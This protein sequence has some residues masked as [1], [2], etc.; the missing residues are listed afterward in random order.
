MRPVD[1]SEADVERSAL[2]ISAALDVANA[3]FAG[4]L[5]F[6]LHRRA[7]ATGRDELGK[8]FTALSEA[9][10]WLY[11]LGAVFRCSLAVL[12]LAGATSLERFTVNWLMVLVAASILVV[13]VT[14]LRD[15]PRLL[16]A[17]RRSEAVLGVIL[18]TVH[19][20]V[21]SVR[22]AGLSPREQEVLGVMATGRVS[23]HEIADVLFISEATAATH[24]RNILRKTGLHDRRQLVLNTFA[25]EGD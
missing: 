11:A 7:S 18:G 12:V 14:L 17:L 1:L 25:D 20:V 21:R 24:V 3:G 4:W 16:A 5:L 9:A 23:D 10:L 15:L 19:P 13:L 8:R 22:S 2:W 6:V